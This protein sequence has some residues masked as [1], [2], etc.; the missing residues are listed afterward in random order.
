MPVPDSVLP[1]QGGGLVSAVSKTKDLVRKDIAVDLL[2]KNPFNPNK[3]GKREFDLLVDNIQKTGM[4]D[5][6]MVRPLPK[7]KGDK[8]Q[9]YRIVGGHHRF[10]A[11]L[12][13]GFAEIPCTI[14]Q[15][16]DFDEDQE[17]FQLVRMNMIRGRMDPQA[18]FDLY[19]NLA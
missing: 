17:Q 2:E 14:V 6:V 7:A 15:H 5:A 10:E 11:A 9:H 3:M 19:N 1:A 8:V 4:T 18:F 16:D 13:L 12:Y